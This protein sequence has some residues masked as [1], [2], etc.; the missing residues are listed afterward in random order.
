MWDNYLEESSKALMIEAV[1]SLRHVNIAV[2]QDIQDVLITEGLNIPA[3]LLEHREKFREEVKKA[4]EKL[5][6]LNREHNKRDEVNNIRPPILWNHPNIVEKDHI[7]RLNLL[8][9]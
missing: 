9:A 7:F 8:V 3:S 5:D 1:D 4:R 2:Q 6:N